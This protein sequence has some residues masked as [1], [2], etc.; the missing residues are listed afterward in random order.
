MSKTKRRFDAALKAEVALA[1]LRNKATVAQLATKYQLHPNQI[2]AWKKQL[3]NGAALI[4]GGG[5]RRKEGR[6]AKIAKH[7]ANVGQL[8]VEQL[9]QRD[10]FIVSKG[11]WAEFIKSTGNKPADRKTALLYGNAGGGRDFAR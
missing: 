9:K 11:L 6:V 2:Y 7:Y 8:T 4:F 1:T 5:R 10:D 3:L